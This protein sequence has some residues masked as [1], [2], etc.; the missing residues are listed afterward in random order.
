MVSVWIYEKSNDLIQWW[1]S[2]TWLVVR[3]IIV[4]RRWRHGRCHFRRCCRLCSYQ[5]GGP[6]DS[7]PRDLWTSDL[8]DG[9]IGGSN[10]GR[11]F[12]TGTCCQL[13]LQ[14][15]D[16]GSELFYRLKIHKNTW[17]NKTV[18]SISISILGQGSL[19]HHVDLDT[20]WFLCD[21]SSATALMRALV[22]TYLLCYGT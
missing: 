21:R 18:V 11:L 14:F 19:W 7:W 17:L 1:G 10:G 16:A 12:W 22:M 13:G 15:I 5:V 2:I 6:E 4:G 8:W 20:V 3:P 9:F